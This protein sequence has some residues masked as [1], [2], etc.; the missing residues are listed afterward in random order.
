MAEGRAVTRLWL[1]RHG[2]TRTKAMI[3]HTDRPADL[4]DRAALRRLSEALP[5][6]PVVSSDL[7]RALGTADAIR[8]DRPRLPPDPRLREFHYGAWEGLTFAQI[9]A[10]H[11]E[12]SARPFFETPGDH[13][14]PGGESWNDVAA[15]VVAALDDHADHREL[16]VVCHFGVILI[17]YA[18]AAGIA[19]EDAL[20]R[21]VEP[22]SLTR[23]DWGARGGV[24]FVGETP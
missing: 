19:P 10:A 13:R 21:P 15:R 23:L 22:L 3:G 17:L 18:R 2:P 6:A 11:G 12:G 8:G 4:S 16:I 20:S 9:E 24:H 14:P 5:D 7:R 1:V